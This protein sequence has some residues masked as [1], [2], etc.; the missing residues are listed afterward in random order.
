[1]N[2]NDNKER[3]I[4]ETFIDKYRGKSRGYISF[5][6]KTILFFVAVLL[7]YLAITNRS[8]YIINPIISLIDLLV[9]VLIIVCLRIR[10]TPEGIKYRKR[11]FRW[12]EIKTIGIAVTKHGVP[13]KFYYKMIYISKHKH[14]KPIHL[15]HYKTAVNYRDYKDVQRITIAEDIPS[16]L[17]I[18][19]F[20][21]RLIRHII[22]YWGTDIK[23]LED[24]VGWYSYFR[25]HNSIHGNK[26]T[27]FPKK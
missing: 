24:T 6:P 16:Y 22:A 15:F 7:P 23:N 20:N 27:G 21:R 5:I 12:D 25:F 2:N 19:S 4:E 3:H 26:K 18:A 13:H 8:I 14:E 17:I 9:I 1:M 10:V 11:S